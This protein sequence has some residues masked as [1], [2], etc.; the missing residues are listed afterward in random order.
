VTA[1]QDIFLEFVVHPVVLWSGEKDESITFLVVG[2]VSNFTWRGYK[3]MVGPTITA[4]S[5]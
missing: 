5:G 2:S 4:S 3:E 1:F